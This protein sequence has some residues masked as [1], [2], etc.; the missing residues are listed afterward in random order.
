MLLAALCLLLLVAP[1]FAQAG[2]A[3]SDP[4]TGNWGALGFTFLELQFDG[5]GHVSGTTIWRLPGENE[6]RAAIKTGT[7]DARTG[8]LRLTGEAS[9]NGKKVKYLIEGTIKDDALTGTSK[10]GGEKKTLTFTRQ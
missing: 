2:G 1:A 8:V 7:F 4:V 9:R 5:K 3:A 6:Q 10:L